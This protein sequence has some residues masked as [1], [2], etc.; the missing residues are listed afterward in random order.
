VQVA[1]VGVVQDVRNESLASEPYPEV[2]VD[3]RHLLSLQQRLGNDLADQDQ[4]SLGLLSFAIR[5]TAEPN[6]SIADVADIVR[7]TDPNAAIDALTPIDHLVANS[8]T[9]QR[10]YALLMGLFGGVAALLATVGIYGVLAH[11]VI[12]RTQEIG[13]R[14]AL[15]ARQV[16]VLALILRKGFV[17][18]VV[19]IALGVAGALAVTR[20][21][22]SMLFAVTPFDTPTFIAV[23]LG[24]GLVALV[25]SYIPARR[26]ARVDPLVALRC[27]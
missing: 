14:V 23:S 13:I 4:T 25:A 17:L 5:T 24:F 3:Y 9:R 22:T 26:A 16:Q 19:G 7:S 2:F 11:A 10:F 18:T 20:L 6:G 12:Q 21:L 8:I 15:G 1:V 27:E